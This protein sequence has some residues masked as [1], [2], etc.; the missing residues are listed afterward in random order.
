MVTNESRGRTDADLPRNAATSAAGFRKRARLA[1]PLAA[2]ETE[3]QRRITAQRVYHAVMA[4]GEGNAAGTDFC[5]IKK[6]QACKDE[7]W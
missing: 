6:C 2:H 7:R 5:A 4:G 1:V 3:E